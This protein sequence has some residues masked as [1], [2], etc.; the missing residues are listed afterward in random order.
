MAANSG[1]VY[2]GDLVHESFDSKEIIWKVPNVLS[3][4]NLVDYKV[5]SSTFPFAAATW[6]LVMYPY[7]ESFCKSEGFINLVIERLDSRIPEHNMFF[8]FCF[9][10]RQG[11]EFESYSDSHH[12]E[13]DNFETGVLKYLEKSKFLEKKNIIAP[14]GV[15]T[16]VCELRTKKADVI[17]RHSQ[18]ESCT[19]L[20]GNLKS[21]VY[22]VI[23]VMSYK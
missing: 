15:L 4:P 10:T 17:D 19:S 7:G 8:K 22:F 3:L 2:L 13:P 18:M 14:N 20:S 6:R 1:E 9:K 16:I 11:K 5:C 21:F 12:F 23:S